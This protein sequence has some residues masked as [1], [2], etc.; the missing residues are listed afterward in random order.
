MLDQ[1]ERMTDKKPEAPKKLSELLS[2]LPPL[3]DKK[4]KKK[5]LGDIKDGFN[6]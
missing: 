4:K 6:I 3:P 1:Y 5:P 2:D